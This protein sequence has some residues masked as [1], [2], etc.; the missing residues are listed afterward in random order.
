[1]SILPLESKGPDRL[2]SPPASEPGHKRKISFGDEAGRSTLTSMKVFDDAQPV[3]PKPGEL[4]VATDELEEDEPEVEAPETKDSAAAEEP[5]EEIT[6]HVKEEDSEFNVISTPHK[7]PV[8]SAIKKESDIGCWGWLESNLPSCI[9]TVLVWFKEL[10]ELCFPEAPAASKASDL[11][12]A[13]EQLWHSVDK[14]TEQWIR[15]SKFAER[16]AER[17]KKITPFACQATLIIKLYLPDEQVKF[18]KFSK[19]YINENREKL[20]R[21]IL[22]HL[23]TQEKPEDNLENFETAFLTV[24]QESF[25]GRPMVMSKF[26]TCKF[27]PESPS[28]T[29]SDQKTTRGVRSPDTLLASSPLFQEAGIQAA[30]LMPT[31]EGALLLRNLMQVEDALVELKAYWKEYF[32]EKDVQEEEFTTSVS[33]MLKCTPEKPFVTTNLSYTQ[34]TRKDFDQNMIDLF[35]KIKTAHSTDSLCTNFQLSCVILHKPK[36][37]V[38]GTALSYTYRPLT[39]QTR[40]P[41]LVEHFSSREKYQEILTDPRFGGDGGPVFHE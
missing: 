13:H 23:R 35:H 27:D 3:V 40:G 41:F 6:P 36:A 39:D 8:K 16:S 21:D 11:I 17:T 25:A 18:I 19:L 4:F 31:D 37:G 33:I 14:L 24:S 7:S 12:S 22:R 20:R 29:L 5:E 2:P 10:I 34:K 38:D 9:F 26:V 28:V 15:D 30:Q 32:K 1:M